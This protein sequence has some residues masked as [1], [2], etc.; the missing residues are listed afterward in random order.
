MGAR[1]EPLRAE[2]VLLTASGE[3]VGEKELRWQHVANEGAW[4]THARG[5]FKLTRDR[6]VEVQ[7]NLR[8]HPKYRQ[9]PTGYGEAD[10]LP[11]D[12]HHASEK[13]PVKLARE[14]AP[15][16]GWVTE[17]DVRTGADGK[18]QMWALT[19][20]LEPAKSYVK[21]GKY[22]GASMAL[23]PDQLDR[24]TAQPIGWTCSSIA[25][26]ND[27]F[28]LG[29]APL[30]AE[31]THTHQ[32]APTRQKETMPAFIL[33]LAALVGV[34]QPVLLAATA[35]PD[36]PKATRELEIETERAVKLLLESKNTLASERASL[37]QAL[38]AKDLASAAARVVELAKAEEAYAKAKPDFDAWQLEREKTETE[39]RER[40]IDAVM[41]T[42]KIPAIVRGALLL[43]QKADPEAFA[44][45]YPITV[46]G[47]H[48]GSRDVIPLTAGRPPAPLRS[49]APAVDGVPPGIADLRAR[50]PNG[51]SDTHRAVLLLQKQSGA[52][53][54]ADIDTITRAGALVSA[55]QEGQPLTLA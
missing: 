49:A 42:H 19:R 38:N 44:K 30:T 55:L 46:N 47:V 20:W 40:E 54:A 51:Q 37:L 4:V 48:V 23:W 21:D 41:L 29:L 5:P 45:K 12:F 9:G 6:F 7:R 18:A 43:E 10:V 32:P 31:D 13:D 27:P 34:G 17:F 11:W 53:G 16:Q 28:I 15:A 35:Q 52:T 22:Q 1:S 24:V 50:V 2:G 25:L 3:P 36:D 14:G 39:K 26:T 33:T 8:T